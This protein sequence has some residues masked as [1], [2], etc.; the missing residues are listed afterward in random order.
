MRKI[1]QR[2][3]TI[4]HA[5]FLICFFIIIDF[6]MT[7]Q[8]PKSDLPW[9]IKSAYLHDDSLSKASKKNS[10]LENHEPPGPSIYD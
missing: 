10:G 4:I 1:T 6:A 5:F 9:I 8:Y 2:S 7:C 3:R